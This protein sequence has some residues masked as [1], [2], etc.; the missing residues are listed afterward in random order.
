VT[1]DTG[2]AG[3]SWS[4]RHI[5]IADNHNGCVLKIWPSRDTHYL[6]QLV[7]CSLSVPMPSSYH[8]AGSIICL[9]IDAGS[10]CPRSRYAIAIDRFAAYA[11]RTARFNDRFLVLNEKRR[12]L[13][14]G[15]SARGI[16]SGEAAGR[17]GAPIGD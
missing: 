2:R 12:F 16:C 6:R 9:R 1:M 14:D 13:T 10:A 15:S 3:D 11:L 4:A 17:I 8:I 5:E 7:V